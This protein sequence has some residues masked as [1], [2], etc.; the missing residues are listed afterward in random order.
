M[1]RIVL[2]TDYALVLQQVG[3]TGEE[4]I[5]SLAETLRF[6]RGRLWHI[7]RSLQHKGLVRIS[8][9]AGRGGWI[10]LSAKGRRVMQ[11]LWPESGMSYGF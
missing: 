9:D 10:T 11:T 7:I 4:D 8:Q 5:A 3:D 1:Q 2:P 6:D